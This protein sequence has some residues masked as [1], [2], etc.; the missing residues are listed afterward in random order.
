MTVIFRL[1][2]ALAAASIA[3][4]GLAE[5][6]KLPPKAVSKA[7]AKLPVKAPSKVLPQAMAKAPAKPE[8]SK[9]S[10]KPPAPKGPLHC[11]GRDPLPPLGADGRLLGHFSYAD[12]NPADLV[13]V[14]AGFGSGNCKLVHKDMFA[15]LDALVRAARDDRQV[16]N[17]IMGLSCHRTIARQ[18]GLFCSP[19]KL[20]A[21][22]YAGQAKWVAPPGYSEHATGFALDFAARNSPGCEAKTCFSGTAV[23]RWLKENGAKYG[24]ETSFPKDNKQG[25]SYEPWHWRWVGKTGDPAA[26]RARVVFSRAKTVFPE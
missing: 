22:G 24:F 10:E 13:P 12:V 20:K 19:A 23:S 11:P 25:V 8:A 9:V 6:A 14:P 7:P 16:G 15:S 21:R 1:A 26:A 3:S 18:R 5:P 2:A 17:T 4:P